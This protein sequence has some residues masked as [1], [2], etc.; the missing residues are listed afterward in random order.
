MTDISLKPPHSRASEN[1]QKGHILGEFWGDFGGP[2]LSSRGVT[3]AWV[4]HSEQNHGGKEGLVVQLPPSWAEGSWIGDFVSLPL[5][6]RE[7]P[8]HAASCF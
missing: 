7:L 2:F 5:W 3:T 1:L 6:W 8:G 4:P